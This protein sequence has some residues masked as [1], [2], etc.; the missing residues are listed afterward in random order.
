[1]KNV[2]KLLKILHF[3]RMKFNT[4]KCSSC[5]NV[6]TQDVS[7]YSCHLELLKTALTNRSKLSQGKVIP[8]F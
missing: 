2:C 3:I 5:R 1:M 7:T 4:G 6:R 8:M